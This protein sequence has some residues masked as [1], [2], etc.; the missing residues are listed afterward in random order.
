MSIYILGVD[1]IGFFFRGHPEVTR[2]IVAVPMRSLRVS[3][4]TEAELRLGAAK[5]P[6]ATRL[7][8]LLDEFLLR[9]D[10]L[11]WTSAA[12]RRF[13]LLWAEMKGSGHSLDVFELQLA[14]HV[15][16]LEHVSGEQA[17]L[18]TNRGMFR[19][20]PGLAVEDWTKG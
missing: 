8:G 10:V 18:V 5:R 1:T 17:V 13:G 20:V 9:V 6:G 19:Q 11:P 14:A 4:V 12:A 3:A 2:R 7:A 15:L 16:C